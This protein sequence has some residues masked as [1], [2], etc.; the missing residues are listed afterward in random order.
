LDFPFVECDGLERPVGRS[1]TR[2]AADL[3]RSLCSQA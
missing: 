3:I 2:V 1:I